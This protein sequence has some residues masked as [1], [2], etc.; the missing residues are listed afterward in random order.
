MRL[1]DPRAFIAPAPLFEEIGTGKL[2]DLRNDVWVHDGRHG[3]VWKIAAGVR[4]DGP[5]IPHLCQSVISRDDIGDVP[6]LPHD[7]LYGAGG[8]VPSDPRI[9][10]S[11]AEADDLFLDLMI[12]VGVAPVIAEAAHLAVRDFGAPHWRTL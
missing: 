2:V 6:A 5:S 10:Y 1:T 9:R 12:D 3:R 4:F 7:V 11:R 8:V